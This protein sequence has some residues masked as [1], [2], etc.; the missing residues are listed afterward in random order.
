VTVLFADIKGS[1]E[2]A[3]QVDPEEWHAIMDRFFGILSDGVHRF[4]GTV[5]QY[6]GDGIMALFGAPLAHEDH[7]QRACHAALHLTHALRAYAQELRRERGL[8]FS[9][10]MG[11]NSGEVV[12]GSI[13]DDLRMDYTAQGHTVGLAARMEQLCEPGR[14]Y[15]TADTVALVEGFF[16][17]EDLGAF[18]VKGARAPVPVFALLGPGPLRTRLDVARAH[19]LSRL[20]EHAAELDALERALDEAA[21]GRATVV[22]ISADAGV[23]KSR[24]CAEF[25]ERAAARGQA[26]ATSY[27]LAHGA[28]L[29]AALATQHGAGHVMPPRQR[30]GAPRR[31]SRS[32]APRPS[33]RAGTKRAP[34]SAL[35]SATT[36][37][38]S[39]RITPRK[40]P[41]GRWGWTRWRSDW[42]ASSRRQVRRGGSVPGARGCAP[43][44]FVSRTGIL[45]AGRPRTMT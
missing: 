8:Q 42:P 29:P 40:K 12:V 20:V 25:C 37:D 9:V 26:V 7:A 35:P 14:V 36:W 3:E 39:A 16:E 44:L 45:Y 34:R 28:A 24:V 21:G 13:G 4:D 27:A 15:L 30:C 11:L 5:N 18:T 2:L 32:R 19:G 31:S 1:L 38:T 10:R 23:G 22:A 41:H 33:G 43:D 6:T 17:L